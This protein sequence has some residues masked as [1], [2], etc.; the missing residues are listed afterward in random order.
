MYSGSDKIE[1]LEQDV[2][3]TRVSLGN[4]FQNENVPNNDTDN[5]TDNRIVMIIELIEKDN[6]ITTRKLSELLKTS[7]IT[8]KRD[9]EKLKKQNKI[10]RIGNAKSGYWQIIENKSE[11]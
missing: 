7:Q 2:F 6:K 3:I 8:I 11:V 10:I 9:F 5:D 4:L 1:F